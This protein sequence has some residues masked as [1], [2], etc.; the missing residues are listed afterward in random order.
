MRQKYNN[1]EYGT[2]RGNAYVYLKKYQIMSETPNFKNE[3]RVLQ[4]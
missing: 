2:K 4:D 3:T 1:E